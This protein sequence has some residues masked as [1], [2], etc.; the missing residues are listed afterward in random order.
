MTIRT[1]HSFT[2]DE[3]IARSK[4][5]ISKVLQEYKG[6]YS[7][8]TE[9]WIGNTCN[10]RIIVKGQKISGKIIV[11]KNIVIVEISL[12][13]IFSLFKEIVKAEIGKKISQ[14]FN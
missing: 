13:W 14:S 11:D 6:Q 9:C 1:V 10:Y 4:T 7:N 3:A 2:V 5:I 12:P 8:F